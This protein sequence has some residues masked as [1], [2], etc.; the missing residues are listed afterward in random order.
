[1]KKFEVKVMCHIHIDA[2]SF[3]AARQKFKE[4]HPLPIVPESF[5]DCESGEIKEVV[6]ICEISEIAIFEDDEYT[7]DGEGVTVLKREMND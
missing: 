3:E 5:Q 2:E 1:M 7:D 6:G 4:S